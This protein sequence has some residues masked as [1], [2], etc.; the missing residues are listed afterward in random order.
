MGAGVLSNVI[1]VL[2]PLV[3]A[4]A[5]IDEGLALFESALRDARAA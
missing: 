2:V 3:A 5:D 4:D 1:R